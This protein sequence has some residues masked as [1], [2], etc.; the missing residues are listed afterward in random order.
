MFCENSTGHVNHP[1]QEQ[2][3]EGREVL[4]AVRRKKLLEELDVETTFGAAAE[5]ND[6]PTEQGS[7]TRKVWGGDEASIQAV[8]PQWGTKGSGAFVREGEE[9]EAISDESSVLTGAR[10][11]RYQSLS[12]LLNYLALDRADVLF[13]AKEL[14][15]KMSAPQFWLGNHARYGVENLLVRL[16]GVIK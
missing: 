4:A 5:D 10:L 6:R 13:P 3:R 7:G 16:G 12:A 2:R 15:R 14:M 8:T 9:L 11:Q 1:V